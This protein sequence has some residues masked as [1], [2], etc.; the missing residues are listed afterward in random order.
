MT[1]HIWTESS[2]SK[3]L[4]KSESCNLN[5]AKAKRWNEDHKAWH[6]IS[7]IVLLENQ[8]PEL[9]RGYSNFIY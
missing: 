2:Y 9:N 1:V 7:A 4:M 3:P 8:M 6:R 5:N